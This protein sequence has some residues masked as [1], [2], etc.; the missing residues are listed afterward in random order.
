[1]PLI[2]AAS[3]LEA[4]DHNHG[5]TFSPPPRYIRS[6]YIGLV[7]GDWQRCCKT[8]RELDNQDT[9]CVFFGGR[10]QL[11]IDLDYLF[12]VENLGSAQG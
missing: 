2:A 1:M 5:L 3:R 4:V 12:G 11:A 8:L 6:V 10:S 7:G 9:V